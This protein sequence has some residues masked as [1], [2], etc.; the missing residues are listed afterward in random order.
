MSKERAEDEWKQK[1][2]EYS[3]LTS[4]AAV[5]YQT[6]KFTFSLLSD[7]SHFQ[8][9]AGAVTAR[10]MGLVSGRL[11]QQRNTKVNFNLSTLFFPPV[12]STGCQLNDGGLPMV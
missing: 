4:A 12:F 2:A 8:Q 10:W 3:S 11:Q 7:K 5:C 6:P 9:D 1:E